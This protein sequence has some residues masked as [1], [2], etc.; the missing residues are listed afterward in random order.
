MSEDQYRLVRSLEEGHWWF[1]GVRDLV[2]RYVLREGEQMGRLTV[3]DAGCGSGLLLTELPVTSRVGVDVNEAILGYARKTEGIYYVAG[4]VMELP[5][6]DDTCDVLIS[7]D[8]LS[9]AGVR[10]DLVAA[11]EFRRVLKPGGLLI[12]NLP[13][14][15]WLRSAH[16]RVARTRH[17]YT[18]PEV[19]K[20]LSEA[21]FA[22]IRVTYRVTLVFPIVAMIRLIKRTG[23]ATDVRP[24]SA[25][26]NRLLLATLL[27]EN[28]LVTKLRMP[29]GLSVFASGRT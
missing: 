23:T 19:S 3:L 7:V 2:K 16:D 25:W 4:S 10:D 27:F 8:V 18:S 13:A 22:Q 11:R 15:E 5:L 21:G 1:R 14:Y 6:G 20:L 24:T 26:A 17:R 28:R 9:N 12:L 29:F